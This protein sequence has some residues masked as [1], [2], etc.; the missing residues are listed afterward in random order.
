MS[1]PTT[2][3]QSA[4]DLVASGLNHTR[5]FVFRGPARGAAHQGI[6]SEAHPNRIL[7]QPSVREY[8][9]HREQYDTLVAELATEDVLVRIVPPSE[10]GETGSGNE[11]GGASDLIIHVGE[12]ASAILGASELV[13]L[14]KE[15]LR[16][17]GDARE[18]RATLYL[19]DGEKRVFALGNED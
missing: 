3:I 6:G 19:A 14:L 5:K 13:V 9:S 8:G 11:A 7:I 2:V 10:E 4:R 1:P 12:V 16:D 18:R 15:R 17:P